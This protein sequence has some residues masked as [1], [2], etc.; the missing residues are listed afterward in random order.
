M[1]DELMLYLQKGIILSS[2][3]ELD[4]IF[5]AGGYKYTEVEVKKSTSHFI[6]KSN[7]STPS[8][9]LVY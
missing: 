8:Q 7:C 9:I 3:L 4:Y 2:R 1:N 6:Q 5:P